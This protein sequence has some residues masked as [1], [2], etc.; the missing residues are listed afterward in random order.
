[1]AR[2]GF[3]L[4]REGALGLV[5][6]SLLPPPARALVRVGRLIERRDAGGPRLVAALTRLGPSYVKFGQFLATRPDIVGMGVARELTALQ[7]RM[8]PFPRDEAL[9]EVSASLGRPWTDFFTEIGEP[10]A[11][12]SIAQVHKA[13]TR[14]E[15]D[16]PARVV[17]LKALRPNVRARFRSD[18]ATMAFAA[19]QMERWTP[20]SRRLRPVDVAATLARSVGME[21]DLRLEAAALSELGANTKA[22]ADVR[23][24]V[25]DWTRTARDVLTSEWVDGLSLSD[26]AGI[27]AAG[28][29]RADLARI[30]IQSFLKQALRDGF[31]HADMHQGNLFVDAQGRL[32]IVDCGIMGRLG[33]KERRFLA[34]IL[35]GFI[36]RDYDRVAQVHFDAGYVPGH[37]A[38]ADFAQ[39]IRAVGEPIHDKR[40]S[41]FSMASV[42]TLLFEITALF[43]M[44]TR[45]EL[46]ML[47]KTMVVVEGVARAIDPDLD[48]W[49]TAEP[50]VREWIERHL[51]PIGVIEAAAR[52]AREAGGAFA[53]LPSLARRAEVIAERLQAAAERGVPIAPE[54]LAAIGR[55]EG[56]GDRW[57]AAGVWAVALVLAAMFLKSVL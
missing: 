36:T 34:E 46:V 39:A 17:A 23:V 43:D 11:A 49:R 22:D 41:E 12:A 38:V 20:A 3:V 51:G 45:T 19:R 50:V 15:P 29:D 31:F 57:L 1:M 13:R 54:S 25:V 48:M 56:R 47:Q 53:L 14:G 33:L 21:M 55:A 5:D 8:P 24:P 2:I 9:R 7:D 40:A 35:F 4:A 27:A 28:H 10:V 6:A 37:H 26:P 18:L 44:E 52:G 42:L 16:R 30:V 32:V